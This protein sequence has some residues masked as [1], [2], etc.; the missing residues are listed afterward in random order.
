MQNAK[1]RALQRVKD[2]YSAAGKGLEKSFMKSPWNVAS[3]NDPFEGFPSAPIH[4]VQN[5]S[6][7]NMDEK[8]NNCLSI[9]LVIRISN[10][11]FI[12]TIINY[13][14]YLVLYLSFTS[15][16]INLKLPVVL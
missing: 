15:Y 1:R 4:T 2:Q 12:H 16:A 5:L 14:F 13:I 8:G 3:K 11:L 10:H 9:H 6:T 7:F